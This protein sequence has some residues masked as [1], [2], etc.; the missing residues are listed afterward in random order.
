M[1]TLGALLADAATPAANR[2]DY[3]D[4]CG[5]DGRQVPALHRQRE[6][7]STADQ[8]DQQDCNERDNDKTASP[9]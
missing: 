2:G 3:G 6:C 8:C 4:V 7:R 1:L 5:N 9:A